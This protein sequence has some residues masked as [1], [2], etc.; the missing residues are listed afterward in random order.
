VTMC[1]DRLVT[2]PMLNVKDLVAGTSEL[3]I[4]PSSPPCPP[5]PRH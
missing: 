1:A 3:L 5:V 2:V 4:D